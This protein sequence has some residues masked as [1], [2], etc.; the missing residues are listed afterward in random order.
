MNKTMLVYHTK[1]NDFQRKDWSDFA[2][3]STGLLFPELPPVRQ[4]SFKLIERV[5]EDIYAKTSKTD[6]YNIDNVACSGN[7]TR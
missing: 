5:Y 1:I 3:Y 2:E 4:V 7:R 6:Q